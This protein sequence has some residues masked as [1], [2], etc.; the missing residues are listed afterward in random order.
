MTTPPTQT[1]GEQT[2]E[3]QKEKIIPL[4]LHHLRE[5][6]ILARRELELTHSGDVDDES[7]IKCLETV[8]NLVDVTL[9]DIEY[10]LR[11]R[12]F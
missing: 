6:M 10:L 9:R 11:T 2:M 12:S 8:E 7:K 1:P 5:K 4:D 3:K